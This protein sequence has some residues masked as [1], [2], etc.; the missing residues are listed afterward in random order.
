M[1]PGLARREVAAL[2]EK[3]RLKDIGPSPV[4]HRMQIETEPL[5]LFLHW[6]PTEQVEL[7]TNLMH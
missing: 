6:L 3:G 1:G 7:L 5:F 2:L 4:D